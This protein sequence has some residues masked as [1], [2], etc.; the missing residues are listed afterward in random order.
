MLDFLYRDNAGVEI[1]LLISA[2]GILYP[3]EIKKTS[4]PNKDMVKIL[5]L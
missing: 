5:R 1:D 3:V 2:D 4:N